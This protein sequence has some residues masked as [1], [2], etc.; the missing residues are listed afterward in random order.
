MLEHPKAQLLKQKNEICLS[1]N[2]REQK[3]V[4][5]LIQSGNRL[6]LY[7]GQ[8]AGKSRIEKPST[9]IRELSLKRDKDIV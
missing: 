5:G 1:V 7:N 6:D 8:S 4:L 3:K 9:T 2:E